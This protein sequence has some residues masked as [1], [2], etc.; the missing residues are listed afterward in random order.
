MAYIGML[1]TTTTNSMFCVV[2]LLEGRYV[3]QF[4]FFLMK[5]K[6]APQ[7]D[8]ASQCYI[9]DGAGA[10]Y[11]TLQSCCELQHDCNCKRDFLQ[12]L[13]AWLIVIL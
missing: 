7:H 12:Y 3:P 4:L 13:G 6:A 2:L 9:G 11:L 5:K 8:P 10:P 1:F